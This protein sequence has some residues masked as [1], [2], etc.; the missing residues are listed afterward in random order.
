ME[1]SLGA[2]I[3][4]LELMFFFSGY[5]LPFI[6]IFFARKVWS[7]V[8]TRRLLSFL[9]LGYA[10][11]GTLYL[12]LQLKNLY[13]DFSQIPDHF[14]YSFLKIFS[15]LSILFW[16]PAFRKRPLLSLLHGLVFFSLMIR[17]IYRELSI[18]SDGNDFLKN[19]IKIFSAS[20]IL[21]LATLT[22]LI[23]ISLLVARFK[24]QLRS[25][26]TPKT[27]I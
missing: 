24:R 23:I 16:L 22:I 26:H 10:L 18:P 13:P 19:D 21:N 14:Q 27:N 7:P 2:Y 11:A 9:P 8:T 15:L 12:G 25:T 6:I 5:A 1:D 4:H 3:D 20:I 17:N